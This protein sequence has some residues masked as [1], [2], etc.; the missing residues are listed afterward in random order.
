[1][2]FLAAGDPDLVANDPALLFNDRGKSPLLFDSDVF[3][4]IDSLS[5]LLRFNHLHSPGT[6]MDFC[7]ARGFGQTGM[8]PQMGAGEWTAKMDSKRSRGMKR[9]AFG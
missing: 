9:K 4:D 7:S 8:A 2:V 1:V 6:V 5:V 3:N